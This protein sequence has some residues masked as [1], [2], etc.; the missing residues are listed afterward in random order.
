M[1]VGTV[2]LTTSALRWT[3]PC[4]A[5]TTAHTRDR[6]ASPEAVGGVSTHTNTTSAPA[7]ASSASRVNAQPAGVA[8]DHVRQAGLV[9]RDIAGVQRRDLVRH[10]V[11][12]D[13]LVAEICETGTGH[14]ADVP[15]SEHGDT[16]RHG[17][18]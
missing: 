5:S 13:H 12:H 14:Q 1:P 8:G 2:D 16:A 10:D 15:G 6:S 9:D 7:A 17:S 3:A 4:S 11:A 18:P